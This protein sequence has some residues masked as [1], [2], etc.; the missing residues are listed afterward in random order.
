MSKLLNNSFDSFYLLHLPIIF[1]NFKAHNLCSSV[2]NNLTFITIMYAYTLMSFLQ[3][4]LPFCFI[5]TILTG[6]YFFS[7]SWRSPYSSVN[8][9][10]CDSKELKNVLWL[11]VH[12]VLDLLVYTAFRLECKLLMQ[13]DVKMDWR[14]PLLSTVKWNIRVF[15]LLW[16]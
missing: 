12:T 6:K 14:W 8:L 1:W 11:R 4:I 10:V 2:K 9:C 16:F 13:F 3:P 15:I 7:L 5:L